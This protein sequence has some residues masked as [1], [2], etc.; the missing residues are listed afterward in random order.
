LDA[1]ARTPD[2]L[3]DLLSAALAAHQAGAFGEA[4]RRYRRIISLFPAHAETYSR[5]GAALMAQG[6]AGDAVAYLERALALE[7]NTF[8]ALG[9][10]AQAYMATG[11]MESA[12]GA[13]SRLLAIRETPQGRML[14]AECAKNVR[15]TPASGGQF[16][17]LLLRALAEGWG[18]PR[19]LTRACIS[20]FRLGG[21]ANDLAGDRLLCRL[22]ES[23][24]VTDLG[25]ERVLTIA[26]SAMLDSAA[27][28]CDETLLGFYCALARQCFINE[29]VFLA[30]ESEAEAVS[31]LRVSLERALTEQTP[32]LPLWPVVVGA[33]FPLHGLANAQALLERSWPQPVAAVIHQQ[34]AEP[35]EERRLAAAIPALTKIAGAVSRAV[36]EQYE[37]NPYPRWVAAGSWELAGDESRP[38]QAADVLIA[39][40]GTGMSTIE[41][42]RQ[43]PRARILAVDLSVASLGYAKRMAQT[44]GLSNVEF[45]Q[46][47][48]VKLGA[49]GRQFD[50]IESSGV[51][52]H[53]ADPWQGWRVLLS[54]LR[55]GGTMQ[56]GLYSE[57]ARQHVVAARALIAERSYQPIAKDIRRCRE[58]I[59]A[60][61]EGSLLKSLTEADDFYTTS[62]CRDMLFHVQEH[63]IS[64]P[65]IK[66]FLAA[67][68]VQFAGFNLDTATLRRFAARFPDP[69]ALSDLDRWHA[70]ETGAPGTFAG[71]YQFWVRKPAAGQPA[72]GSQ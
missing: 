15:F 34:V 16:R 18:R 6:K 3:A 60:A 13:L 10:L 33:Y 17:P 4:E 2:A 45:A 65:E 48:I 63:R 26:R 22:L 44:L 57:L 5:L 61:A 40:C 46:A 19:E 47:D 9:N 7:P 12:L 43:A 28:E 66:S 59:M 70:Y 54:L 29:Y 68:A 55:P 53:L 27:D 21:T 11:R 49:I 56:V 36:R 71:M 23:D 51:L 25:F 14:F 8:A 67:N 20:L 1:G 72:A 64:L 42:A 37:E 50:F 39:G 41:F 32:C 69:A 35:A 52:H 58:E 62:E 31:Q 38:Q 24:P 30:A